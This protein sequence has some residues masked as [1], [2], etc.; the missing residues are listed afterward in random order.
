M[1]IAE[2]EIRDL[3]EKNSELAK[4]LQSWKLLAAQKDKEKLE[5]TKEINEL[6]LKISRLRSGG[7]ATVRKLDAGLQAASEEAL[8]HLVQASGAVARTLELTKQYIQEREEL[9][10]SSPK[11]SHVSG[12]TSAKRVN[13]VPPLLLGGQSIQPV[14]SLSRTMLSNRSFNRSPNQNSGVTHRAV[15][16]HM[17]QDV[18]I[19]LTR[20]DPADFQLNNTDAEENHQEQNSADDL[21]LEESTEQPAETDE[22]QNITSD[23]DEVPGLDAVLEESVEVDEIEQTPPPRQTNRP[24]VVENP[25]EGPS[26]LL[27]AAREPSVSGNVSSRGN[28]EPDSTTPCDTPVDTHTHERTRGDDTQ[29]ENEPVSVSLAFTPTVRRRKRTSSPPRPSYSPRPTRKHSIGRVLKVVVAKMRLSDEDPG[30]SG[31]SSPPKRPALVQSPPDSPKHE[32][33]S[34]RRMSTIDGR[35]GSCSQTQTKEANPVPVRPRFDAPSPNGATDSAVIVCEAN[36]QRTREIAQNVTQRQPSR[37]SPAP[38]SRP[39]SRGES[40]HDY[41]DS[42]H[43]S[44]GDNDARTRRTR[45]QVSYKEK[46]LNRKLRR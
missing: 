39:P 7:A 41:S 45:R 43:S 46:P 14:V 38:H 25:L 1:S 12:N 5:L 13:E 29:K 3:R 17:L 34:R 16:M 44:T 20:I 40:R 8:S 4:E 36:T 19:P 33:L 10:L 30:G 24:A 6:R 42:D 32:H 28:L 2:D 15:P 9:D 21:G 23:L 22:S 11:W 35:E 26:W 37:G 31:D 18:Y 27:D